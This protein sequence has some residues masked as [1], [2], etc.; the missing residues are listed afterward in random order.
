MFDRTHYKR[1]SAFH[2]TFLTQ[3]VIFSDTTIPVYEEHRL[4]PMNAAKNIP[5][6]A[7]IDRERVEFFGRDGDSLH[8]LR[9]GTLGT[10]PSWYLDK[11]TK[12][13][14][15]GI[16]QTIPG[17]FD[18]L[19]NWTAV[20]S[21]STTYEIATFSTT[22]YQNFGYTGIS[23]D[24]HVDPVDQL[25]V[26]YGGSQLS[27]S[28]R[29]IY[30]SVTATSAILDPAE[31]NIN[32]VTNSL[33]L[34][35]AA[36]RFRKF[37]GVEPG[38]SLLVTQKKGQIWTGTESILTSQVKQAKFIREKEADLPDV[39]FYGGDPR[40]QDANYVPLEDEN[41]NSLTRW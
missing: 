4:S 8:Q 13:I 12:V 19:Y 16:L 33:I 41:G 18:T 36:Y 21:N 39:Y 15:Q 11:N 38:V 9:R 6:V 34:N 27:K 22:N 24:P 28:D 17:A 14:D 10:G 40:L 31:F 25:Q 32:T 30:E 3:D 20:T 5:G 26:F 1:L 2:S 7:L 37:G 29:Y 23:L 35:T